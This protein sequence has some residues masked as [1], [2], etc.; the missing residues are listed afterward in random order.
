[1]RRWRRSSAS[2]WR[3]SELRQSEVEVLDIITVWGPI[4]TKEL[5]A[6]SSYQARTVRAALK[7]LLAGGQISRRPR[8][9]DLRQWL[10]A[11]R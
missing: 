8:L 11:C 6:K 1:M 9:Q 7:R 3:A 2:R 10:Y 5:V 4:T